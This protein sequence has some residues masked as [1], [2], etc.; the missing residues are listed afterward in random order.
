MALTPPLLCL[1]DI[2]MALFLNAANCSLKRG[3]NGIAFLAIKFI[4]LFDVSARRMAYLPESLKWILGGSFI[5]AANLM[6]ILSPILFPCRSGL[7]G[8]V[9]L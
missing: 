9:A 6:K 4:P 7:C 2:G 3:R 8:A 1:S 5:I